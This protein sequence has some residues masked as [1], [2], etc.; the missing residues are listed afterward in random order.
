M[1][2]SAV[3]PGTPA[4]TH[5]HGIVDGLI[6]RGWS[7][8]IV[9]AEASTLE[10]LRGQLARLWDVVV[11]QFRT[12]AGIRSYDA[13]Y[14]RCHFALWPISFWARLR[15]VAV[16]QEINGPFTDYFAA[17]PSMAWAEGP[18]TRSFRAQMRSADA[19]V[20]VT[21]PMR[22]WI[23][24]EVRARRIVVV[25][26][27]ADTDRFRP[28]AG[29]SPRIEGRY[30]VFVG[31]LAVWQGIE[32][33]IEAVEDREWPSGVRLVIAGGG[34]ARSDVEAAAAASERIVYL[35]PVPH[36]SVP[37]LIAGSIAG[38]APKIPVGGL[39]QT[40]F[41]ALK[42]YETLACGVPVIASDAP[43]HRETIRENDCGVL[44]PIRDAKALARA[45]AVLAGDPELARVMGERG[46]AYVRR[47]AS[48]D[49]RAQDVHDLIVEL[50][51]D[52]ALAGDLR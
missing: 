4:H 28:D 6:R 43:G 32:T 15:G 26:N 48:W 47:E 51:G 17:H 3:E 35:G 29:G 37:G 20:A 21:G 27:G 46:R 25:P 31:S 16:I 13:M 14:C 38:L 49:R 5:V 34:R 10:G 2:A 39:E 44:I 11:K 18:V 30:V 42:L 8:R 33:M 50:T 9:S 19:L 52:G 12:A 36:A 1:A 7:V 24:G 22:S 23:E 40:G 45:V 41:S